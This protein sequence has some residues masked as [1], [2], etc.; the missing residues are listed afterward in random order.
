MDA[1]A[2]SA[3]SELLVADHPVHLDRSLGRP[4]SAD[5]TPRL[6]RSPMSAQSAIRSE[7]GQPLQRIANPART[8][9]C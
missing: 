8:R 7:S 6:A 5:G 1:R 9:T 2:C 3:A 4:V